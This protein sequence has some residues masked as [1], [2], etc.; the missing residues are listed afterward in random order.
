MKY[1]GC[2]FHIQKKNY[3]EISGIVFKKFFLE[4]QCLHENL[5]FVSNRR[6]F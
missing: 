6:T 3:V 1:D 2:I 4:I 5:F